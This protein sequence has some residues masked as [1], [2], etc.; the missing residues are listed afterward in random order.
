MPGWIVQVYDMS[1]AREKVR[2]TAV[3]FTMGMSAGAPLTAREKITLCPRPSG[4]SLMRNRTTSPTSISAELGLKTLP[5][6]KTSSVSAPGA[7]AGG[8]SGV[9]GVSS[10]PQAMAM[11]SRSSGAAA[12]T[13]GNRR[14]EGT[15]MRQAGL[16]DA[17][18]TSVRTATLMWRAGRALT[19][20]ALTILAA[21]SEDQRV[22][23]PGPV[24]PVPSPSDPVAGTFTLSTVNAQPVPYVLYDDS[25]YRLALS[26]SGLAL[27]EGGALELV[28]TTVE[29]VAGFPSTYVDTLRGQ[30]QQNVGTIAMQTGDG[31]AAAGVWDGRQLAFELDFDGAALA[32]IYRRA[33]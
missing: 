9:V 10:P 17:G 21:C 8:G 33:P 29:T 3:S 19:V 11:P 15:V 28:L 24:E 20:L 32:V 14:R 13:D 26:Q 22:T 16:R 2:S 1:P 18:R 23:E 25:G 31:A 30:W 12:E 7:G 6:V 5:G 4:D 27:R